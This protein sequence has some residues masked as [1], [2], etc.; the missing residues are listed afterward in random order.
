MQKIQAAIAAVLTAGSLSAAP[1]NVC[2]FENYDI[3]TKWTLWHSGGSSTATVEADPVNP[4]NKVLHIVLKEWGCHPE[5]TLPTPLRGKELTDRYTM[6]KYD[7]YRVA[8]DNDDWK[9]FALFLGE[10]ELYRDEGYPHQGNRSEWVSKTYNLNAAESS[11]NSDV[12]RLG[13]HHN[14]SEFYID[15]IVLAGPFDDFVTTDDGGLLD[16][17]VNNT[18][19][20]YSNISDNI[21]IPYGITTNVRTSRYSQWT[22]KVY[23][24]GRLNIYAGGERSYIGTQSSKGSTTPDWSGMTGSVHI[25]PYKDVIGN[26]GFYGLLM[27]SGTFQPDNLEG[28]RINEVFAP[29]EVTLHA[30]ATI[31][32]ESGT[33]GIRFGSLSTEEGSTL[34]GYYKK[35]SA[36][37]YYIMGCNGKD[38][39]LA[40][41]IYNSQAG[42]KVG[43]IKEGNGTYTISG[44]DNNI[45][46]GI[47]ILAGTVSANNNAAEAE[48]GKKSGSTGKNGTVTVFKA[49]TLSGTGSVA[50]RTEV[51][52]K[53]APGSDNPGTLTFAD[54]ES[55][56]SNVKVVM[57]P[58]GNII[59]RLRNLSDYSRVNIKGSISYSNKT[60][61]FEDSDIMPRITIALG[62]DAS[63]AVNDEYVLLTATAKEGDNWNFRIV[64][65]KAC[66]WVVEQRAGQ[67]GSF[68]I[69]A[70]VTSTDYSGQGDA[71]DG[72]DE[73][74]GDKGEWPDDD[75]SYDI[76]DPTPLRTYAEKLGKH[77]G[78][79]FASYRYNSNNSQEAALAG[80]EFNMLVAENE[81]KFDATEPGRNQFS[82]GGADAVT[83]AA[84]RNGQAVRG[85][86]LAWHKQVSAWVSQDGVKNN[87]N[88]SRRELLDI[89]KNHIFNVV[90]NYKGTVREWDVCNEVLDDD[91]SI[92]R[93][94][95]D[96]Y[97]LRP[98]IWATHIGEEFIDSAFVW[99]HQADPEARL[100]INDYNV[101]FAGNAKTEAYHNL[102]K[103][104]KKSGVPIDGC[105]LQCHLTTG[106]LDTLKLEKNIRR[107]AD[108]GLDCIITELDIALAN[109]YAADALELQAKEYGAITRVFL[110]NDNCPSML[111]WG[112]SD[113]HSWRQ[114]KPLLFDSELQPK[115]AYYNVH[116]QMRLAAERAGQSGIEDIKGDETIVSTRYLDL[117]GRPT[118]QNG[119]VI[120]VNT[121]SDGSVKAIKKVY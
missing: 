4:T 90:G 82:Y 48:T 95:P 65:P 37:S 57:H 28:S 118:T 1:L 14:N 75:W 39:T 73:N 51:Y 67:D 6:V 46:G 99:A 120:E 11:N 49:G 106:Q 78:V 115:P 83:G 21:L 20:N 89:L 70:R 23:G 97:T 76:T 103:R 54:Y 56:V 69:V 101:E 34:D 98:S 66:T 17:C 27:N 42:N 10:Q 102:V 25:Y 104:L 63:P 45:A 87:N 58:E 86:T 16:Y 32:V 114:N 2:D 72:E 9:Q 12:I 68:S 36:N 110:R 15:N 22:G 109:P 84:Y 47:R 94:N 52:G 3:G 71:G 119:L 100:Y 8:D 55:A 5:F 41:K 33:R 74:P 79:A 29:S 26:C 24:Q 13:I 30:G 93:T 85:H 7:L 61:D 53:V 43:L 113:N 121:Y 38:A 50:S 92:V 77:I 40:G 117:Y 105:G 91:Q 111:M 81:M 19:S 59:C 107:Y 18:S 96:A 88:Y 108:M 35:S 44:N 62:E 116:A 80:R 112:I 31:A 64:Y 60:E